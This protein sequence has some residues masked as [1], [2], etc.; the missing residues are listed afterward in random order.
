MLPR[1]TSALLLLATVA[2][3]VGWLGC[4]SDGEPGVDAKG[5]GPGGTATT[6]PEPTPRPDFEAGFEDSGSDGG[7]ID[8][9]PD[10]GDTCIDKDDPGSAENTAKV[11]PPTDDSQNTAIS[12]KGVMNGPVDVD[13]YKLTVSDTSFHLLQ[14]DMQIQTTGVEMCVFVKCTPSTGTTDVSACAGGVMKVSDIG[15]KGCCATGPSAVA[16]TWN[17]SGTNDSADLFIRI[18]QVGNACLPYTFAYSF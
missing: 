6:K 16:P 4:A 11:L 1:S 13:F 8:P 10:G 15:T 2:L 18:K 9:T 3:G 5:T 7:S 17:C 14:P 12:Q